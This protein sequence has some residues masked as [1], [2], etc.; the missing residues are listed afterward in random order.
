MDEAAR[1]ARRLW[2]LTEHIHG[3]TYFS[4]EAR[5]AFEEAG[6]RGFWR[7]YFAGRAAPMGPVG[8]GTVTATFFGFHHDFVSRAVPGVWDVAGPDRALDAR[9]AGARAAL[10]AHAP[11]ADLGAVEE[12]AGLLVRALEPCSPAGRPLFAANL[13]LPTPSDPW[14]ALWQACTAWREHRGD[15]HVAAL[16]LAGL[17]GC[18]AHVLRVAVQGVPS[19]ELRAAR[20]WSDEDWSAAT[21]VL[22]GRGLLDQDGAPTEAGV[23]F[24]TAVEADTDAAAVEP[25]VRLGDDVERLDSILAPIARTISEARPT[26]SLNVIGVEP[27]S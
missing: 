27:P 25:V 13:L 12:A 18:S 24:R 14:S 21:A 15:G 3:V 16:V 6:L 22:I 1:R 5:A 20:G 7:G 11:S 4:P 23:A 26:P 8:S 19:D 2:T 10:E 9:L 17:D